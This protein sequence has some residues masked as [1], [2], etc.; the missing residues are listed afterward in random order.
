MRQTTATRDLLARFDEH[1]RRLKAQRG[2]MTFA[3]VTAA[4]A[5]AD[6][7]GELDVI[8]FRL[9]ASLHHL[10]LDEMQ[11]TSIRQWQVLVHFALEAIS[12]RPPSRSFF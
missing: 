2:A 6:A 4:C 10:L 11:D 1:Y 3:D 8:R 12:H 9:D 7:I 5:G